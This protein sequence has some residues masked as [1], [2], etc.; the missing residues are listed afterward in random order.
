VSPP[1]RI[2]CKRAIP[3]PSALEIIAFFLYVREGQRLT[4][5]CVG[6]SSG[7]IARGRDRECFCDSAQRG[8]ADGRGCEAV[9]DFL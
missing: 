3:S 5:V 4:E 2:T 6:I 1:P 9:Y 7:S 8:E